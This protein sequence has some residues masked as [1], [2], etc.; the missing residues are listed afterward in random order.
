MNELIFYWSI[1]TIA[2]SWLIRLIML[3]LVVQRKPANAAM[4]WLV[5]IFFMPWVGLVLYLLIGENSLPRRRIRR[6][7][8]LRSR[9]GSFSNRYRQYTGIARPE[10]CSSFDSTI[11]LAEHLTSMPILN[12]ND[13]EILTRTNDFIDRLVADID[14]ARENVH[15]M[16]YIFADDSTGNRIGDA[17]IRAV[18]RGVAC[19]VLVDAVGS[20]PMLKTLGKRLAQKDISIRPFL[21]VNLLRLYMERIDLRNHRKIAVIDGR[22]A[23]TGSQNIVDA[24][25][26]HRDLAWYDI[27]VRLTGPVVLE[28]QAVFA[29]DWH[30]ETGEVLDNPEVFTD[31]LFTGSMTIQALPSGP[32]Y[33]TESYQRIVVAAIYAA[34]RQVTITTPYFVPDE[35]F[36]HALKVASQRGVI[37]ELIFPVRHDQKVVGAASKA[38]Y[39]ELLDAGVHI[40]EYQPGLLHSKSM[41]IDDS[42]AFIGTSNFD[43]R[44]FTLNFEIN[45]VFYGSGLIDHLKTV[46]EKYRSNAIQLTRETWH[47]QPRIRTFARNVAKLLSPLL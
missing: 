21:T 47:A 35:S 1:F 41:R 45:M 10:L 24:G 23:Y 11:T 5:V 39:G 25:Y 42:L 29:G 22:I 36:M 32:T 15:L 18:E 16:F 2:G 3:A 44:S 46:Q 38:Y 28:L 30:F 6:Y 14:N 40:Y 17:L 33:P 27:M 34:Q 12:G 4:G 20:R 13:A 37:V 19:R 26:G 8:D 7:A 43:I 31:P 9:L